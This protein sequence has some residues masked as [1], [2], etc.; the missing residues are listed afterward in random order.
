MLEVVYMLYRDR[1]EEIFLEVG[2][3]LDYEYLQTLRRNNPCDSV[4]QR[5]FWAHT[6]VCGFGRMLFENREDSRAS[7]F[8]RRGAKPELEDDY[9]K[10]MEK[11]ELR[12]FG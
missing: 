2:E 5:A 8:K 1:S 9:R 3:K 4:P 10:E 7:F 6:F 12:S 11:I